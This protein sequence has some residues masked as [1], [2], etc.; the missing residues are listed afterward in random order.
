V[1]RKVVAPNGQQASHKTDRVF[2]VIIVAIVV[3]VVG[4]GAVMAIRATTIQPP[5]ATAIPAVIEINRIKVDEAKALL[6]SGQAVLIDARS[7][8]SY[9]SQHA[10]GAISIPEASA[11]DLI[12]QLP[13]DKTL[14][15]YCT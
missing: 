6:D 13:K 5:Q 3:I 14:I 9:T 11:A 8:A 15:F 4:Y 2:L 10:T 12:P 7:A 1:P